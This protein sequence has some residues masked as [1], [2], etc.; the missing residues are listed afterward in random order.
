MPQHDLLFRLGRSQLNYPYR[1]FYA[2]S[3]A[4]THVLTHTHTHAHLH[5]HA[6]THSCMHTCTRASMH[7]RARAHTHI[8]THREEQGFF[9]FTTGGWGEG[10]EAELNQSPPRHT[11]HKNSHELN[12][13]SQQERHESAVSRDLKK[14]KKHLNQLLPYCWLRTVGSSVTPQKLDIQNHSDAPEHNMCK[15][16]YFAGIKF[17]DLPQIPFP[18]K[19]WNTC[20]TVYH[21]I[22]PLYLRP[23]CWQHKVT[24]G[25]I[26]TPVS[27]NLLP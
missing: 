15:F 27:S 13:S 7:A 2:H 26:S 6:L 8:H 23:Y 22:Q 17:Q 1:R 14:K 3:H 9:F 11:T 10:E 12:I 19:P 21:P 16:A 20:N 18:L 5:V 25:S 24:T 4:R